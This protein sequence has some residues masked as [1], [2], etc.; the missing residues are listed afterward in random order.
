[1]HLKDFTNTILPYKN[2]LFRFALRVVGD[3]KEAEDIVQEV[4]IKLWKQRDRL[5]QYNNTEAW[6]ITLTKNLAI[7]KLRSKHRQNGNIE[8]HY[9][10]R[11]GEAGPDQV[12]EMNDTVQHIRSLIQALP[13]QQA[14][15]IQLRDI[16]GMTYKEIAATLD[17]SL[18]LVKV[19]LFRARR[20]IRQQ[21]INIQSYGLQ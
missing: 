1:M 3:A 15:V 19:N 5:H 13:E 10:L 4:F 12:A 14:A 21:L 18:D 7:D 11:S 17:I 8:Q 20:H 6:C 9:D 16:E 2:K